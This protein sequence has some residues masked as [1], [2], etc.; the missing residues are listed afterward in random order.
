MNYFYS[1]I[2]VL[3]LTYL[4]FS[5]FRWHY[6][7]HKYQPT[8]SIIWCVAPNTERRIVSFTAMTVNNQYVKNAEMNIRRQQK[9]KTTK[10]SVIEIA[11]DRFLWKKARSIP[12]D[13][14]IFSVRNARFLFAQ[15]A[16]PQQNTAAICLPT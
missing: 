7:N 4:H 6:L 10:L 5:R 13:T 12:Q 1:E 16:E 8:P 11:N 3:S 2:N 14:K 9:L 15:N